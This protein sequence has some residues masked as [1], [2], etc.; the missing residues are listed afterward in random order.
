MRSF[1][2]TLICLCGWLG[3][4]AQVYS[5]SEYKIKAVFLYNFTHF[6]EWPPQ[7][8][9]SDYSSFVIGI[10]G[11]DPFGPLIDEAVAGER[12]KTHIIKVER[13]T[14]ISEIGKCNI[15]YINEQDP[16]TIRNILSAVADKSILTVSDTPNFIRWGGLIRFYTENNKIHLEINNTSARRKHITISS[17]L[18]RVATVQ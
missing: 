11:G 4:A 9:D 16:E 10:I 6:V 5:A 17:K 18:L 1:L 13:Y 3:L 7:S 8:F 2:L 15:L 14:D 12:I